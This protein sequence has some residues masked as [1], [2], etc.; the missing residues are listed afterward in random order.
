MIAKNSRRAGHHVDPDP[1]HHRASR[2][3]HQAERKQQRV[4]RWRGHVRSAVPGGVVMLGD[5]RRSGSRGLAV[6]GHAAVAV[7][8]DHHAV[9]VDPER[10]A[11]ANRRYGFKIVRGRRRRSCPLQGA[12]VPGIGRGLLA[13]EQAPDDVVGENREGDEQ[14]VR[15]GGF[16]RVP[17]IPAHPWRIGVDAPRHSPY[18]EEVHRER[19]CR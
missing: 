16:E 19:R 9:L 3:H 4:Q 5:G 10:V 7:A 2:A 12:G 13:V 8:L 15:G 1:V 6:G 14:Q 18:A 17:E 11:A